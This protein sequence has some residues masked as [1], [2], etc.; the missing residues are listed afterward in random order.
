MPDI[1]KVPTLRV[2]GIATQM[3]YLNLLNTL[4]SVIV[5]IIFQLQNGKL[6]I[7]SEINVIVFS[8]TQKHFYHCFI[9]FPGPLLAVFT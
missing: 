3:N 7:L 2:F 4:N 9:Y 6:C 8:F 5:S 1:Y